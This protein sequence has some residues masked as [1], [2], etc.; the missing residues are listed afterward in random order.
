M[1]STARP[2]SEFARY[3]RTETVGG[4][5]LLGAAAVALI[6]ANSPLMDLYQ[7]V[8]DT[9]IGTD[10][11][12][13]KLSVGDWAKDGLLALF[14][15]VVGLELKRELVIGELRSIKA[16]ALP[17]IAAAGGMLFPAVIALSIAGGEPGMDKAWAIPVATDIAFALGV[18]ALT[19]SG[20]PSSARVFL[21]SLAVVDDLGAIL[22]IAIVFTA[23][24]DFV[25]LAIAAA[26]M[27]LY[28]FLQYK[29]VRTAWLYVPIGI[30]TWIAV[31]EAGIHATIAGVALGMLTRVKPDK[32]EHEAPALRLEHRLQPWSAGLAVPVF[33]FFAAGVP[34]TGEALRDV[35]T[36]PIPHAI[37][38]GLIG[39][40]LLGI[41]ATSWVVVKLGIAA[42][43]RNL[44][45][46]DMIA[47]SMLG[48]VG[49]TV[50]LLI[51]ELS[52]DGQQAEEAKASVLISSVIAA[53]IASL[54]LIRR[55]KAHA[56]DDENVPDGPNGESGESD[57]T[58]DSSADPSGSAK[59]G[60][61]PPD[62]EA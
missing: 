35:F 46:L 51:A 19:G 26:A 40:K 33:A 6:L 5:L 17:I 48:A 28:A 21:L 60:H 59:G 31:H 2:V 27:A 52:L 37:M 11:L 8:R 24:F 39:G 41:F 22:I 9:E 45:H 56:H 53:L 4:M 47:I 23:S 34:L 50:S 14:F 54:L 49:F 57:T 30:I 58:T 18:L 55:S 13:L 12:H 36:Q 29:R 3:L 25:A 32:G 16:A 42:K 61:T 44:G 10:F 20:M 15:F 62:R 43:P 7:S 1:T 38:F